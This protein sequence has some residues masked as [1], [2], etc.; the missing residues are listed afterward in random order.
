[1]IA[2]LSEMLRYTLE[3]TSQ[4]V[5]LEE[6]LR[7]LERYLDIQKIRFGSRLAVRLSID[8]DTRG[9]R[10]PMLLLQPLAENALRHGIE[11]SAGPGVLEI[12]A[13]RRGDRLR[14]EIRDSGPGLPPGETKNGVGLAVTRERLKTLYGDSQELR[15]EVDPEK[16]TVA[17]IEVPWADAD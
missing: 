4:E 17:S 14:L 2:G 10:V 3:Q 1:M 6:E 13:R 8:E 5:P 9:V 15:L 16:G 12:V 11:K 7:L